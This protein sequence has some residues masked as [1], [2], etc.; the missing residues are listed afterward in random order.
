MFDTVLL[1]LVLILLQK[2]EGFLRCPYDSHARS[3]FDST[4]GVVQLGLGYLE[5][6]RC[7]G[8]RGFGGSVSRQPGHCTR[9]RRL[10][11]L[12]RL[13]GGLSLVRRNLDGGWV[14]YCVRRGRHREDR[15]E[16]D[17]SG[18]KKAAERIFVFLFYLTGQ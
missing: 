6:R 16:V 15:R 18:E 13:D 11:G 14:R 9:Q 8:V 17:E 7:G 3:L 2:G 1:R 4:E 12:V 5:R 10:L